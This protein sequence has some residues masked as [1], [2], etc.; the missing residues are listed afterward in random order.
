MQSKS[1]LVIGNLSNTLIKDEGFK[2]IGIA[3]GT[4]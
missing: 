2:G 3:F 4:Y 1:L